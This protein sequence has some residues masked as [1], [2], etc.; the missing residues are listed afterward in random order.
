MY[1]RFP[2]LFVLLR[3]SELFFLAIWLRNH[4]N[5]NNLGDCHNDEA[6]DALKSI[7]EP[8]QTPQN[9]RPCGN[10]DFHFLTVICLNSEY[11]LSGNQNQ[12]K[13]YGSNKARGHQHG[14]NLR[15]RSICG[16]LGSTI[17]YNTHGSF[18]CLAQLD[19]I[20]SDG[21]G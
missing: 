9:E 1:G 15:I 17:V 6:V 16:Q 10:D 8:A 5:Q 11:Q 13:P 19:K 18:Q 2:E 4:Q 14:C 7:M 3:N 20:G 12:H 21:G